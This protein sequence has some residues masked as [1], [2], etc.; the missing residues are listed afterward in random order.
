MKVSISLFLVAGLLITGCA[1]PPQDPGEA[2]SRH[3]D[4]D[5][6]NA[7]LETDS[8][9]IGFSAPS[10]MTLLHM[11]VDDGSMERTRQLIEQGIRVNVRTL[12]GWTALHMASEKGLTEVMELLLEA[13]A[14]LDAQTSSGETAF[15]LATRAGQSEAVELLVSR[16]ASTAPSRFPEMRGAYFGQPKPGPR[17]EPFAIPMLTTRHNH[18]VRAV[19]FS[20]DGKE[21]YWPV[22]DLQDDLRRWIVTTRV[23]SGVWARPRV[24]EFSERAFYDDVPSIS[25]GGNKLFFLSSRPIGD[26]DAANRE[27]IW[28][29]T[30]DGENW[31]EPTPLPD[32]VNSL[33][34]IHQRISLDREDNLY[35]SCEGRNG[36]GSLDIYFSRYANSQYQ[37]PV[38]LGHVV[39]GSDAEYAPFISPGGDYLIFTRNVEDGWTIF[40]SF[41]TSDGSWTPPTDLGRS[42]QGVEGMDLDGSFVT[43]DGESLIFFGE[44]DETAI[45]YWIDASFIEDLRAEAL[46]TRGWEDQR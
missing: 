12:Y 10:G 8:M 22:I 28:F 5:S 18:Y 23:E 25:P 15:H 4:A 34:T 35:F 38:N 27:N 14:S 1:S 16:G 44:R 17:A 36:F 30:R 7:L 2:A 33:G 20:P 26:E 39:N 46:D 42:I 11:A 6:V 37:Q 13:G 24:A 41:V 45:P 40:I 31:S 32:A 9:D 3:G 29:V 21:A 43:Q 19:T